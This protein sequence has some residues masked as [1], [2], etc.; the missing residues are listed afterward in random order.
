MILEYPVFE[1]D[2]KQEGYE[3]ISL[4]SNRNLT[5]KNGLRLAE[6]E[7]ILQAVERAVE[8]LQEEEKIRKIVEKNFQIAKTH[9]DVSL[10]KHDLEYVIS[11]CNYSGISLIG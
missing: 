9:H 8:T 7:K 10:L 5:I 3:Y 4:G 2:L 11:T 1:R 6:P